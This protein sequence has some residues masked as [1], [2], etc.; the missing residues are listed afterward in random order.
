MIPSQIVLSSLIKTT[1]GFL[2][3]V[4]GH[5]ATNLWFSQTKWIS[6]R[7][8]RTLNHKLSQKSMLQAKRELVIFVASFLR[9]IQCD[10]AWMLIFTLQSPNN[11]QTLQNIKR[12]HLYAPVF[13][14][15]NGQRYFKLYLHFT[16]FQSGNFWNF[17]VDLLCYIW[18]LIQYSDRHFY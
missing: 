17:K 13:T 4:F 14:T 5:Y 11:K 12:K 18:T 3:I 9:C 10:I 15:I 2:C 8:V 7:S 16:Y 1:E 6:K